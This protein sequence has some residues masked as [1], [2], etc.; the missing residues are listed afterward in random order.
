MNSPTGYPPGKPV[1]RTPFALRN[2]RFQWSSDLVTSCAFEMET[3]A[4]AWYVLVTTQS[5]FLLAVLGSLQ[6]LGTLLA[7][8]VGVMGDRHGQRTVLMGMRLFYALVAGCVVVLSAQGYLSPWVAFGAAA[9]SGLFR[10][11]DFGFRSVIVSLIV[12]PVLL[13]KSVSLSRITHDLARVFG[14][15]LGASLM[16]LIGFTWAY[17]GIVLFFLISVLLASRIDPLRTSAGATLDPGSVLAQIRRAMRAVWDQPRQFATLLLAFLINLTAFPFMGGLLPYVA[18]DHFGT[19]QLGLGYLVASVA[20]GAVTG[21]LLLG[22]LPKVPRP[23]YL[24]LAFSVIW[25]LMVVVFSLMPEFQWALAG[26]FVMGVAQS[27][28][29]IPL[30]VFLLG[31]V[32]PAI[33]GAILGLRAMAI[34]GLPVGLMI[35]GALLGTSVGLVGTAV[36]FACVGIGATAAI[37][38]RWGK[39]L[40]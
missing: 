20:G 15:L 37:F 16:A 34:Y 27:F 4:L 21:A 10:P 40:G 36:L 29:I 2:F 1:P 24:M 8:F 39:L 7:P 13:M 32:D 22:K 3:I 28:C 19:G 11:S 6:Y 12:P 14:A 23:G 30:T 38:L 25:H 18:G 9:L 5:V 33:R 17:A 31:N 26:G 35:A